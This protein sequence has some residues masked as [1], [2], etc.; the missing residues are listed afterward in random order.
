MQFNFTD[1]IG[2][3][4]VI[5][6]VKSLFIKKSGGT[7]DTDA[8]LNFNGSTGIG[9]G[10]NMNGGSYS[11]SIR[12]A[13]I[14]MTNSEDDYKSRIEPGLFHGGPMSELHI[15][16]IF[17]AN[18]STAEKVF[19]EAPMIFY[20]QPLTR[21]TKNDTLLPISVSSNKQTFVF[22]I[23]DN[24]EH[25]ESLLKRTGSST[26]ISFTLRTVTDDWYNAGAVI[27]GTLGSYGLTVICDSLGN[28][29][30]HIIALGK[31]TETSAYTLAVN[32]GAYNAGVK[33]ILDVYSLSQE[34][35]VSHAVV[36]ASKVD[37]KRA[38][39]GENMVLSVNKPI[40]VIEDAYDIVYKTLY[41]FNSLR[42]LNSSYYFTIKDG[43]Y[44]LQFSG[45]DGYGEFFPA[46]WASRNVDL[47]SAIDGMW[48]NIYAQTSVISTSDRK[49]KKDIFPMDE[50]ARTF[51][52]GLKPSTYKFINGTS[53]RTHYGLIAQDIEELLLSLG[54][55][56]KDFA[57]I[58]KTPKYT[59]EEKTIIG[60][61]RKPAK[62]RTRKIVD[63]EY[64]YS[65]RYEELFAPLIK[66]VQLQQGEIEELEREV[67]E[68]REIVVGLL[69]K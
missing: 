59:W 24:T 54:M 49:Q 25:W 63:G 27:N 45:T 7:L 69:A 39:C 47:G 67:N 17:D 32:V 5:E 4:Y 33:I 22:D 23:I 41:D 51:I 48:R 9:S 19:V 36:E 6:K 1:K 62:E 68:L 20:K 11:N 56:N 31:I 46:A 52:L 64:N 10:I 21:Q 35:T 50:S 42:C 37:M 53:D 15:S 34:Y 43:K 66:T 61:D 8:A 28:I 3:L 38:V 16:S 13:E 12:P 55:S 65:L 30:D 44:E 58:I 57:G 26:P 40:E 18:G 60:E 14:V 2:L 29:D